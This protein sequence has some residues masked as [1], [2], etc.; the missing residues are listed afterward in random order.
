MHTHSPCVEYRRYGGQRAITLIGMMAEFLD[1]FLS[2][3]LHLTQRIVE[4]VL[5]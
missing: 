2:Q 4:Q 3:R 5:G 1:F